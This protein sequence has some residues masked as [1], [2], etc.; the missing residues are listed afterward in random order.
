MERRAPKIKFCGMTDPADAVLA[1]QAGA[2]ALG[3]ILWSGS[4]R[5][6]PTAVAAR[7]AAEH[8]RHAEIV[9]VFVNPSLDEVARAADEIG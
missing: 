8:R 3:V 1:V 5:H 9:G 2:W 7:I 6:C 4:S